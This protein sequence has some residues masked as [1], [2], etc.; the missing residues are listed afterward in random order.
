[1]LGGY[2]MV[3]LL[4]HDGCAQSLAGMWFHMTG[5]LVDSRKLHGLCGLV[6]HICGMG[7]T[8]CGVFGIRGTAV[9][10]NFLHRTPEAVSSFQILTGFYAILCSLKVLVTCFRSYG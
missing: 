1:M 4:V 8:R 5:I 6:Q 7:P 10:G 3:D 2:F 9:C